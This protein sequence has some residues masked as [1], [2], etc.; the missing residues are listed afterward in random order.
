MTRRRQSLD[1]PK[2][3]ILVLRAFRDSVSHRETAHLA[4]ACRVS[5][6]LLVAATM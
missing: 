3:K 5:A 2:D 6:S 1:E 4:S